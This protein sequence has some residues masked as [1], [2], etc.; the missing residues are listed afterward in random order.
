MPTPPNFDLGG[1]QTSFLAEH[2]TKS[3]FSSNSL[4]TI[5]TDLAYF[6]GRFRNFGMVV[7]KAHRQQAEF[8]RQLK[9]CF[10]EKSTRNAPFSCTSSGRVTCHQNKGQRSFNWQSIAFVMR[11]LWVQIPP[12]ALYPFPNLVTPNCGGRTCLNE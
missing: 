2:S 4:L 11:R 7:S 12:L 3:T 5:F 10:V 9:I 8:L 6:S 1:G